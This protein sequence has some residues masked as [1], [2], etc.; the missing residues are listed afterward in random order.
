[1]PINPV[2]VNPS[3]IGISPLSYLDL[4]AAAATKNKNPPRARS[5]METKVPKWL[6]RTVADTTAVVAMI[7]AVGTLFSLRTVK[8]LR[9]LSFLS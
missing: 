2:A 7:G 6:I 5:A 9:F 3:T 1:M 8:N 4:V